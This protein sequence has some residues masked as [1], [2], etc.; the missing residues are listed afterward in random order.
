[1][2]EPQDPKKSGPRGVRRIVKTDLYPAMKDATAEK[3]PGQP[4]PEAPPPE[5]AAP[6]A[7]PVEAPPPKVKTEV[8]AAGTAKGLLDAHP[9]TPERFQTKTKKLLSKRLERSATWSLRDKTNDPVIVVEKLCAFYEA[10]QVL[11]DIGFDVKRGEIV[12][13]LGGSGSGK[14]TLL[15]HL[16][17]LLQPTSGRILIGGRDISR[18]EGD[19]LALVLK[20]IGM[21]FQYSALF[22]SITVGE[23]VALPLR[24]YTDLPASAIHSIVRL[25]LSLVG[26]PGIERRMPNELSGGMKKRA[27]LA[28]ALALD[29]DSLFFDEPASGLDPIAAAELDALILHL[30][31]SFGTT[32]VIVTHDLEN[33]F[34]VAHRILMLDRG[35]IA[36]MGTPAEIRASEDPWV[37]SFIARKSAARDAIDEDFFKRLETKS[38]PSGLKETRERRQGLP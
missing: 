30:N 15:K 32:M 4:P 23:N 2:T 36:A 28:R 13:I 26:L 16:I 10:Q 3:A 35:R 12:A 18:L 17:G 27:A 33:A 1:M 7:A 8:L 38:I 20:S 21:L 34:N 31:R 9:L 22:N 25:K 11:F 6:I 29:P 19:D 24:E 37:R 14:T 5:P